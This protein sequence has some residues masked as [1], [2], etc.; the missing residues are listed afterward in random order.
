[1]GNEYSLGKK[2]RILM[3]LFSDHLSADNFVFSRKYVHF[4]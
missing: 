4:S 2:W 1:M 3:I